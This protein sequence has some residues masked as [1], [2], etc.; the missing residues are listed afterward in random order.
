MEEPVELA[1]ERVH[2]DDE[3]GPWLEQVASGKVR[4]DREQCARDL[5]VLSEATVVGHDCV[6][7]SC[8]DQ[9]RAYRSE[10]H[11]SEL[12]SANI[13][14]AVFCLKKKVERNIARI[15]EKAMIRDFEKSAQER[16][17]NLFL[18]IEAARLAPLF[19][20]ARISPE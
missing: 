20:L 9:R 7:A 14:Y 5:H 19:Y 10:E 16:D 1:N 3:I 8:G 6:R 11:T 18:N 15:C 13:S 17:R 2:L 4:G 12:Q